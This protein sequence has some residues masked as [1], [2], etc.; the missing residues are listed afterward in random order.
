MILIDQLEALA[1]QSDKALLH[2]YG[3]TAHFYFI[4]H[5]RINTEKIAMIG[6]NSTTVY[7]W[8]SGSRPDALAKL[9]PN[10]VR[11]SGVR[12]C[13]NASTFSASALTF[14]LLI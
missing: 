12:V 9:I 7:P 4:N 6:S 5:H 11:S 2:R 8:T 13:T 1:D 14:A 10:N 3:G